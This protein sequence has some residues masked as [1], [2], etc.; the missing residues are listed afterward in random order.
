MRIHF[1]GTCAGTEPMP[2][3]HHC[4]LVVEVNGIFYWFDAGENCSHTAYTSGLDLM[5]TKAVFVSHP[6]IDHIGGL[7]NL[8]FCM[9]KLTY[10]NRTLVHNNTLQVFFPDLQLLEAVKA[11]AG[12]EN[13]IVMQA[14]SLFDG[15]L[16]AD[17]NVK[18]TAAHNF[19][20]GEP[21]APGAWRSFSFLIEAEGKRVVFSGDVA[22]PEDLDALQIEGADVLIMETGHHKP[23]AVLDYAQRRKI[24]NLRYN[25]HGR[26]ILGDRAAA[27]Q[28]AEAC[29]SQGK[30]S[31]KICYDGMVEAF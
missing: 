18:V 26:V 11:V 15:V 8:F 21:E 23:A 24:K 12:F 13:R 19:H 10:F 22:R 28:M 17:E 30:I 31:V 7:A 29:S 1:L 27:E 20:L 16:F 25:H 4:S 3:I 5:Q 9:E 2:G 14:Q 6:H